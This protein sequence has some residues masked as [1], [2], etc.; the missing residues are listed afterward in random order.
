MSIFPKDL[1]GYHIH[2]VGI[3]G[4]GMSALVEICYNRGAII[5]GSDVPDSFYTDK[6]LE[7]LNINPFTEFSAKNISDDIQLVVYSSAYKLDINPDLIEAK[8][9]NIP[10]MLYSDALGEISHSCYSCGIAGVHGKTTTTGLT[11]T[12][13]KAL[14]LPAQ[15]LAG[16]IIPSFSPETEGSCTLSNG[17]KYFVAE[18]CEY[19]RHFMAFSPKK[20]ILTSVESDHQDYYPTFKDIQNAFLDYISLLPEGGELI[21]CNDDVGAT[22]TAC[23][24]SI[25]RPDI[26][27]TPY[28]QSAHKEGD[29]TTPSDFS[30]IFGNCVDGE[31]FF[32]LA[33]I[34]TWFSLKV[35]GKHMVLNATA[36]ISLCLSL[37]CLQYNVEHFS[38]L[39]QEVLVNALT[40]I[41]HSLPNFSGA[42]RR[43]EIIAKVVD[44]NTNTIFVDDYAHHPT[45]LKTTIAGFKK[46]YPKRIIIVDFMSHTYS[47][48]K[49]LLENFS[50]AFEDADE[51]I[52]HK[53]YGS[54]RES[55]GNVGNNGKTLDE[56]FFELTHSSHKNVKYFSEVKDAT[57]YVVQRLC[58]KAEDNKDGYLFIT[59]G[60]GDN[61]KLTN[62]V[63]EELKIK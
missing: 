59:M 23:L 48:T 4:T 39:P 46:F 3:K 56:E 1:K 49:A 18:T 2:F 44:N 25:K 8:K 63:L 45:A 12:I 14:D 62:Y 5:T 20:I 50:K 41:E 32:T 58:K 42:K 47:R 24:A 21:Y 38:E 61:W 30:I 31:Q 11:G 15:V 29:S 34:N 17:H 54:A 53:I 43:S 19:Q 36:A 6:I 9:R 60:A 52:L 13:L 51:V 57:S 33:G 16:S 40:K 35:P 26:K 10:T 22:E 27:L 28:G 55:E 37:L 7:K